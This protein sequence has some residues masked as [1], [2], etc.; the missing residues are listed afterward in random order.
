MNRAL[1]TVVVLVMAGMLLLAGFLLGRHRLPPSFSPSSQPASGRGK[2]V[3]Y[4]YDPM[5]PAQHF[6]QPGLSPMG[7]RMV[8]RYA[9]EAASSK[10]VRIDPATV[11]NLGLRT[12]AVERRV[13]PSALRVPGTITWDLRRATTLSARTDGVVNTLYV[14]APFTAIKAG[15]PVASLL[16]PQWKSAIA[17][18][19][20]LAQGQSSD[21]KA[22][23]GAARQR[24]ATLGLSAA[25][26]QT[27]NRNADGSIILHAPA[28]GVVTD[29]E[30][31]QGQRVSAGQ[32]LMTIN[33]LSTVW[34]EAALPQAVAGA[35][36][37][38][39]PVTV[40]VDA[41]P[42]REFRGTVETLLPDV[43]AATRTQRARIVL[44]NPDGALSPG[45]FAT[46][47]LAPAEGRPVPVIPD[48][49]I[50]TTGH[51]TRVIVALGDGGFRPVAVRTGRSSGGYTEVLS[52]LTGSERVVTS[53]QFLIDSEANLSGALGRMANQPAAPS[54]ANPPTAGDRP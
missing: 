7:M 40:T 45:M 25:D 30:I 29:L 38:G 27:A 18:Y 42:G 32:T 39:T 3:L 5:V 48:E 41:Q 10:V 24:L 22:L 49:A 13:L 4:W 1:I 14:R 43:D 2:T 20:A 53:G 15:E 33:G 12:A 37:N 50:V 28:T 16:A 9:G 23:R 34:V 35:V 52:G 17:E 36:R 31:R 44:A 21:A 11:Q 6:D 54:S 47:N 8:P 46:V 51:A 19:E 26:V